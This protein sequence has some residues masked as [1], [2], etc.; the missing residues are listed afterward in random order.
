MKAK[1]IFL[2]LAFLTCAC[3]NCRAEEQTPPSDVLVFVEKPIPHI[4]DISPLQAYL[5]ERIENLNKIIQAF[6]KKMN[7]D[8]KCIY[9]LNAG[10]LQAYKELLCTIELL[11][12]NSQ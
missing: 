11:Q 4:Y 3:G 12:Q 2:M 10:Q 6:P 8:Q 1:F 9:W 5:K 7:R